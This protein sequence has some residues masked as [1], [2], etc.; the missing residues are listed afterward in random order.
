MELAVPD[1]N[2]PKARYQEILTSLSLPDP[3]DKHILAAAIVCQ[4]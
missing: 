2:I 4:A 3:D 1:A